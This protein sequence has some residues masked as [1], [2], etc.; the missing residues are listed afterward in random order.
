MTEMVTY[1]Y[2]QTDEELPAQIM[3]DLEREWA[4]S[5]NEEESDGM[6]QE[7]E[8]EEEDEEHERMELEVCYG[9]S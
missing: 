8:D 3:E 9:G 2:G 5:L 1:D 6:K 7:E 4:V